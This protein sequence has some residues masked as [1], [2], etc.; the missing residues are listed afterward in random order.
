MPGLPDHGRL[1]RGP[2]QPALGRPRSSHRRPAAKPRAARACAGV[3][4]PRPPARGARPAHEAHE[5]RPAARPTA[6]AT[7]TAAE[8]PARPRARVS[9]ARRPETRRDPRV[10]RGATESDPAVDE[11]AGAYA[12]DEDKYPTLVSLGRNLTEAAARGQLEPLVGR[13][14]L[15]DRILDT[16]GKRRANNPCLIGE[17]GVGKTAIVEGL[18]YLQVN[19]P[20]AVPFLKDRR[21]I[22]LNM[23]ALVSGTGLRGAFSERMAALRGEVEAAEG[24]VIVFLDEIHTLV[25]AGAVGDG[26]LDA[27]GELSAAM[28][29][30]AFPCIG[31][32]TTEQYKKHIEETP[33]LQRRLQTVLVPEPTLAE[34]QE[35]LRGAGARLLAPPRRPLSA[36]G[37][38][39]GGAALLALHRRSLPARQGA[40]PARPGRQPRP[41]PPARPRWAAPRWPSWSPRAPRSRSIACS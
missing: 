5:P 33:A 3:A 32:T 22:A 39:R 12:L 17:P 28:A 16:L 41:A 11:A 2:G 21:L 15:V 19:Q 23:G 29:R 36:R 13:R 25:G 10:T 35:I 4:R 31:A 20:E 1:G 37:P 8:P 30:G 38:R 24:K 7:T 27:V 18:A 6:S 9:P 40:E 14:A 26:A 34:T